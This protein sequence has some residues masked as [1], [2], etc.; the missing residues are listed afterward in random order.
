MVILDVSA[1]IAIDG[2]GNNGRHK[3]RYCADNGCSGIASATAEALSVTAADVCSGTAL[4]AA[5][6]NCL[7]LT[8]SQTA[9][10]MAP[11]AKSTAPATVNKLRLMVSLAMLG[12]RS[13]GAA[14][15]VCRPPKWTF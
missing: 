11:T 1:K 12:C 4:A 15:R 9:V 8:H 3:T 6:A 14:D 7:R 13:A 10:P 5:S 2:Y